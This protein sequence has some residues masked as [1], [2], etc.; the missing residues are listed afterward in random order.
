MTID[1]FAQPRIDAIDWEGREAAIQRELQGLLSAHKRDAW[2][3]KTMRLFIRTGRIIVGLLF[4]VLGF[5]IL[6]NTPDVSDVPFA[7]L[8]LGMIFKALAGVV[9]GFLSLYWA[10]IAAFGAAPTE[11]ERV[12]GLRRDAERNVD[13]RARSHGGRY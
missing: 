6:S 3:Y 8:T 13:I 10:W 1:E 7:S 9:L 12:A 11:T 5:V 2:D 4:A